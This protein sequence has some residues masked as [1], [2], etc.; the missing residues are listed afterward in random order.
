EKIVLN[1]IKRIESK[2][3]NKENISVSDVASISGF[4]KR[5]MQKI[6]KE[7]VH[8]TISSYIKRRRLTKAAILIKLTKKS[9]YHIAMDLHFSTQQSFTRAFS[10]EFNVSPL[11]FRNSAYFD[12][13]K[14]LPN[15]SLKLKEYKIKKTR[16]STFKLKALSFNLKI[17]LLNNNSTRADKFR[18]SEV[19]SIL[20][21]REE[22]II[23]TTLKPDSKLENT[24]LLNIKIGFKDDTNF[25]FVAHNM[26]CWEISFSGSWD[27]YRTFGYNFLI[28]LEFN[29]TTYF[30]EKIKNHNKKG[31]DVYYDAKIY[32]PVE[33]N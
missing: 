24:V 7:Q 13:S 15:L 25:N 20:S 17:G 8:L 10:R 28:S 2:L 5:Y 33:I 1:I 12:C 30:I 32:I 29:A 22:A 23:V 21:K 19:N 31:N 4:T 16:L 26:P 11:H 18:F 6:F 14:L 27:D 9:F 3:D